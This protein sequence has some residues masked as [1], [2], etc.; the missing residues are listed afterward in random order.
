MGAGLGAD[1]GLPVHRARAFKVC[2]S[3]SCEQK[4]EGRECEA[5]C[6]ANRTFSIREIESGLVVVN[7]RPAPSSHVN[8]SASS[9]S[10][11]VW[12]TNQIS[13]GN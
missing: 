9:Y 11:R 4:E 10:G 3:H 8:A 12:G 2:T 6:H 7:S 1:R 13:K 5:G